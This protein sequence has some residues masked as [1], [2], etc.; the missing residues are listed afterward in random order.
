MEADFSTAGVSP[1]PPL[2]MATPVSRMSDLDMSVSQNYSRMMERAVSQVFSGRRDRRLGDVQDEMLGSIKEAMR[3]V[4]DDLELENISN[5]LSGG[6]FYFSKGTSR[7]WHYKNLSG[8]ERAAFDLLLDMTIK[9]EVFTDSIYCIDEPETHLNTRVQAGV[10]RELMRLRPP[11]SQM[12]IATHS[13]GMLKEARA[14]D[15]EHGGVVFLDFGGHDMD[16]PVELR[17]S[18][19]SRSFWR[20]VLN[21]ALDDMA[22]LI[23]PRIIV[24]VEGRPRWSGPRRGNAEF[25]AR[26]LRAIFGAH[27]PDV[28]FVSVGSSVDVEDDTLKLGAISGLLTPGATVIRV[29]DRDDRSEIAV[30]QLRQEGVRV[31]PRRDLENYLMADDVLVALCAAVAP[32]KEALVIAQRDA[33]LA[34]Q[35]A[36][37]AAADD[38][39]SISGPFCV[40]LKSELAIRQGGNSSPEFLVETLATHLTPDLPTFLELEDAIFG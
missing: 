12:W 2:Q 13:I 29:I 17:P 34:E 5:P 36:R 16:Q 26:C 10:L 11:L 20:S 22:D 19:P 28:E 33:M 9:A 31:L 23:A 4:F 38:L 8:G 21:V 37:G 35:V 3:S 18:R 1:M 25:D 30:E 7:N 32:G 15:E 24:L 39:K 27:R 6:A 14:L 40:W